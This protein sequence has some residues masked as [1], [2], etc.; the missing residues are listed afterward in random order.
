MFSLLVVDLT[1]TKIQESFASPETMSFWDLPN[2]I[3]VLEA[4]GFSGHRHRLHYYSLLAL[5]VLL[6]GMVLIA[7]AFTVHLNKR[8]HG[9][10]AIVGGIFISFVFYVLG[11]IV[12]ALGLSTNVPTLLAAWTPAGVIV[13]VGVAL[14]LHLEDG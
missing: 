1:L 3:S 5:P 14:L 7:A 12:H 8:S 4:A 10:F 11:D 9:F 2:F 13:M 6:S